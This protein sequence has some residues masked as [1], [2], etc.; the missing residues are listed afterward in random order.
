MNQKDN[1][2]WKSQV[3]DEV[4]IA[5]AAS[6]TLDGILVFK[7]ARVLSKLLGGGRQS[8]D[9]DSNLAEQ[10]AK[11]HPDRNEQRCFLDS[12]ITKAVRTHFDRQEPVRFEFKSLKVEDNPL[13]SHPRGWDAFTVKLYVN[14]LTK[15][16]TVLPTIEI[17]VSAPEVL[18]S[19]SVCLI[20][21]GGHSVNAYT[22]HRI[23]GEKL[24]AYLCS[25]PEYRT[26]INSQ[27]RA[28]RAKD[29]YD[30]S[31]IHSFRNIEDCDFWCRVGTEFLVACKSRFVD[32]QGLTTFHQQW[33]VTRKAY[34]A[35]TVPKDIPF[36]L[37]ELNLQ[38]IVGFFESQKI[39][40][41]EFP[42]P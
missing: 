41:F 13:I 28:V 1:E 36:E 20:E 33:S 25:L 24:R 11:S 32:C 37:A 31:R 3:L 35:A 21:V 17:D 27:P 8:L 30:I 38:S 22:L 6:K 42:F 9:L 29:L 10:F 40:P 34:E 18:H 16:S 7:G 12:E 39:I 15:R 14:D 5:L 2:H 19:S 4:F 26:K 23:A